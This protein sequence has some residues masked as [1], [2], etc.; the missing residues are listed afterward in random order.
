MRKAYNVEWIQLGESLQYDLV[1]DQQKFWGK[2][3][4]ASIGRQEVEKVCDEYKQ[5]ICD[6]DEVR[7]RW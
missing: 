7:E 3:R 6:E 1:K 4:A 2:I 5:V